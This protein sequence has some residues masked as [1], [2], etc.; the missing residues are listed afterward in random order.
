MH[1]VCMAIDAGHAALLEH[2]VRGA[3]VFARWT[4]CVGI[5]AAAASHAVLR[6][7]LGLNFRG[8]RRPMGFPVFLILE[9]VCQLHEDVAR[10]RG[11][12]GICL[13]EPIGRRNMAVGASCY[14]PLAVAPVL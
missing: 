10:A 5:V 3:T 4:D 11:G 6:P 2:G 12:M 7:Q 8:E 13:D 14:D 1:D 9:I